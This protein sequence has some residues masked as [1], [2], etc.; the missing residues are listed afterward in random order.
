M[1]KIVIVLSVLFIACALTLQGQSRSSTPPSSASGGALVLDLSGTVT[2]HDASGS[3]VNIRRGISIDEGTTLET[4]REAKL[5]LRLDDGSEVLLGPQARLVLK[6]EHLQS[7]TTL[8]E[9]FMGRLKAVITKRYTGTPSFQLGTPTAIVAV[10][11]TKFYVEVTSHEVTEV[12]VEQGLVQVTGRKDSGDIVL[13]KP[14]F[15]TRVGPNM[16]PEA[17]SPTDSIRPDVREQQETESPQ[18]TPDGI[19]R[20]QASPQAAPQGQ[21]GEQGP[22]EPN[23][24]Q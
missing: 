8:F 24:P 21:Q 23:S 10:R 13:I 2:A 14:G 9:L 5:L 19:E 7:G 22:T 3:K 4:S 17:P 16:I 1:R 6:P 12:D 20:R 11:G 15:S 18:N